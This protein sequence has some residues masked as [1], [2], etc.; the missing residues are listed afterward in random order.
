MFIA[1]QGAKVDIYGISKNTYS[2][3]ARSFNNFLY[4]YKYLF[5]CGFKN[6]GCFLAA[7]K[8]NVMRFMVLLLKSVKW[9]FNKSFLY[10]ATHNYRTAI[11]FGRS[12]LC[13]SDHIILLVCNHIKTSYFQ[14][15]RLWLVPWN[16]VILSLGIMASL[17]Y[18]KKYDCL[19]L[20]VQ[21]GPT[22]K[23]TRERM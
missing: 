19:P 20:N 2:I 8:Y 10:T 9:I 12:T 1:S 7:L 13:Q 17:H 4:A 16:G 11:I 23:R 5:F 14:N 3:K 6:V 18:K 15:S 22:Y 21:R